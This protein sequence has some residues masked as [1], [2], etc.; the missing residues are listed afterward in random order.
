MEL[1]FIPIIRSCNN[2]NLITK[3]NIIEIQEVLDI[4]GDYIILYRAQHETL[5]RIYILYLLII[6]L[7]IPYIPR[8]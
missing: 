6:F 5:F 4:S 3:S 2:N 8:K 1:Y 7:I